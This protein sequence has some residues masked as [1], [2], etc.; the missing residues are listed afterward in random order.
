[1]QHE[2]KE[3]LVS[4]EFDLVVI[5][6][7]SGGVRAARMAASHGA[8]VAIIEERFFGGTCVNVGC[9]PKKLFAYGA[10][11]PGEFE[12]AASYGYRVADWSFDWA[13]LRDNKTHEIERL[14]GIYRKLLD[15]AG[16]QIFEGHGRVESSGT[17]SVD[18]ETLLQARHILIATGGKPFVPDFPGR[19][20]VRISD[21][22][23]YLEQLPK[24]VAV[25]GGGY[26]ASEFASILNGL[27][28][29]VTQLYRRDLFLRGFD[30]DVR[31]FV[32]EGMRHAGVNLRF[33]TDVTAIEE[34]GA[35]KV[36]RL[37]DGSELRVDEVFYATGR[38]PRL[39][40]LFAD[41]VAVQ[42]NERGAIEVNDRFETSVANVYALGDVI[43]RL[44]L[45]PVALAEGM[46]LAAFL[47]GEQKPEG[48]VVYSDVPTAV[49]CHPN[50]GTVGLT[51]EQALA[52]YGTV[53]VYR[54]QFRPL[55]YTL[56]DI[57][58]RTLMKL[59]VDD[60]SD[61]VVGLHMAG[62]EA[63]EITQGFAVAI[64]MG[65]TKADFDA[66]VGIHPSSAEE[67]V[68]LRQGET[69]TAAPRG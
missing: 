17:V 28:V 59:I 47:F 16:V 9:V 40:G 35:E 38:V 55:R 5:G 25:V 11:F 19:D 42:T 24:R 48:P 13:T 2:F 6:A 54:S 63:A 61:K 3:Q 52:R 4:A 60:S 21:D 64:R 37:T 65:A 22:L 10:G 31:E 69:V 51:E 43:D 67:F 58:E 12:L 1:M 27:G 18:G 23:F 44:Q 26:I 46:W 57:Q 62:E 15:G 68:T 30:K 56:S 14:N 7:G 32:A 39:D 33:N 41:G 45:T 8:K 29:A 50:I 36:V 34:Q 66:T 53:R 20:H 49:F